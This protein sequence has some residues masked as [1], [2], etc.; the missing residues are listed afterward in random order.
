MQIGKRKNA[1]ISLALITA[2]LCSAVVFG[3]LLWSRPQGAH[4][5]ITALDGFKF[6]SDENCTSEILT[7]DILEFGSF[8]RL[9]TEFHNMTIYAKYVGTDSLESLATR[10]FS[11][12]CSGLPSWFTVSINA[13]SH[14]TEIVTPITLGLKVD[15][16]YSE[17]GDY[18]AV[19]TF[20]LT[21]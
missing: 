19:F 5:P 15:T 1:L 11:G 2:L 13:P 16:A 18:N 4:I 20:K 8:D 3:A 14:I 6:Y 9:D 7:T 10:T 17:I 12:N 21:S